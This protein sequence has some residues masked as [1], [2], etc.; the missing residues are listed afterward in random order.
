MTRAILL[1]TLAGLGVMIGLSSVALAAD[2]KA[3]A[4]SYPRHFDESRYPTV[5]ARSNDMKSNS[6]APRAG[7]ISGDNAA[8]S[9]MVTDPN[10]SYTN[11]PEPEPFAQPPLTRPMV[12]VDE[13][14]ET[15]AYK[16]DGK[17]YIV[18]P[19]GDQQSGP[20]RRSFG[21]IND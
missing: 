14:G 21:N 16:R 17:M 6:A 19:E 5:T 13:N 1:R 18:K 2:E 11:A 15:T 7:Q 4:Y 20:L 8:A 3:P 12:Y 9:T 10:E